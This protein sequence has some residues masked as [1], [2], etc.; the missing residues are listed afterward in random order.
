M[1]MVEKLLTDFPQVMCVSRPYKVFLVFIKGNS[2]SSSFKLF[3][4]P[5]RHFST[6]ASGESP[7]QVPAAGALLGSAHGTQCKRGDE[8]SECGSPQPLA[9]PRPMLSLSLHGASSLTCRER[10]LRTSPETALLLGSSGLC[11]V[12]VCS[13]RLSLAQQENSQPGEL[14]HGSMSRD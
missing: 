12:P 10:G 4:V 6:C 14:F 2:S 7:A 5:Y 3:N 1:G 8:S 11:A 13:S 9:S